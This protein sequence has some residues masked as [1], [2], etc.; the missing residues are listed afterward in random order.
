VV[1][2]RVGH[3]HNVAR[4]CHPAHIVEHAHGQLV[5]QQVDRVVL[6]LRV[7]VSSICHVQFNSVL[8]VIGMPGPAAAADRRT[9]S[10]FLHVCG[11][12]PCHT[13]C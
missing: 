10:N 1:H 2:Q 9:C 11:I 3:L 7:I 5:A 6:L 8:S 13:Q 12:T 4:L